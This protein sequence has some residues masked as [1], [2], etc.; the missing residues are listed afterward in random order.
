MSRDR[1]FL[2]DGREFPWVH[3]HGMSPWAMGKGQR[4]LGKTKEQ[5][6]GLRWAVDRPVWHSLALQ[7]AS[8]GRFW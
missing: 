4:K 5:R 6:V 3:G 7:T 1:N 2:E 8:V